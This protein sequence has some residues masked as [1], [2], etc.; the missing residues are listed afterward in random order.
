MFTATPFMAFVVIAYTVTALLSG[1]FAGEP[2]AMD[3]FLQR[4]L[5]SI[6]LPSTEVW[7]FRIADVFTSAGLFALAIESI[8]SARTNSLSITNHGLSLV[9]ALIAVVLFI[10]VKGF[11]TTVFFLLTLMA[12]MDVLVGTVVT[13][14][15]ARRDVAVEPGA[16]R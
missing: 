9:V 13:I 8:K 16:F 10:V 12:L 6:T 2:G 14:V 1:I 5:F 15:T 3:N 11:G 4:T 7:T